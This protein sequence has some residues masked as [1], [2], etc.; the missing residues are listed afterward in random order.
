MGWKTAG[1][2]NVTW[3]ALLPRMAVL[4]VPLLPY[5]T[6]LGRMLECHAG[7]IESR[8][9]RFR[10]LI[11]HGVTASAILREDL[12][13]CTQWYRKSPRTRSIERSDHFRTL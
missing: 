1:A 9:S 12:P 8:E 10:A 4:A 6:N 7:H 13:R 11:E 3:E 5:L 2:T